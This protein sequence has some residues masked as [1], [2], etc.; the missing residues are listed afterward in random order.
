M[1]IALYFFMVNEAL[2]QLGAYAE[3]MLEPVVTIIIVLAGI[4]MLFGAVGLNISANLGSTI[5]G[6]IFRA[7][8]FLVRSLFRGIGWLIS[9]FFRFIPRVFTDTRRSFTSMGLNNV[10]SN[11]LAGFVTL[12][13]IAAVI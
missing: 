4:V 2:P 10:L 13:F 11:L 8:G 5:V 1:L 7:M 9:H 12:L 3:A 6:G